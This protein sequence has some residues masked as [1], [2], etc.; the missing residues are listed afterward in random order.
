MAKKTTRLERDLKVTKCRIV[1][2][3]MADRSEARTEMVSDINEI[4]K[5]KN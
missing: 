2:S 5:E 1:P 4:T 3:R